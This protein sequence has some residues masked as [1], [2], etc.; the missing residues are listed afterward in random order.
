MPLAFARFPLSIHPSGLLARDGQLYVTVTGPSIAIHHLAPTL[1]IELATV[2]GAGV[3]MRWAA[4]VWM[5]GRSYRY[6]DDMATIPLARF[7][8]S[9]TRL[10]EMLDLCCDSAKALGALAARR[11]SQMRVL[12][13][14]VA[15][16]HLSSFVYFV[17][18]RVDLID[19]ATLL[20]TPQATAVPP[21]PDAGSTPPSLLS[22]APGSLVANAWV[23]PP[24]AALVVY[25]S[26]S[27]VHLGAL[28]LSVGPHLAE[29]ARAGG[30]NWEAVVKMVLTAALSAIV[31]PS[32]LGA[33]AL[34]AWI[35]DQ[36]QADE[37]ARA[38]GSVQPPEQ[39]EDLHA[40]LLD[41]RRRLATSLGSEGSSERITVE[42]VLVAVDNYEKLIPIVGG[43]VYCVAEPAAAL[44][45]VRALSTKLGVKAWELTV[46]G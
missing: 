42:N 16:K 31:R 13:R 45:S 27:A 1:T 4:V 23:E 32:L 19:L 5:L 30:G 40:S 29:A 11:P 43:D 41:A 24:A 37:F 17:I 12:L 25:G 21:P 8:V 14:R 18:G 20:P 15:G 34:P 6:A 38:F 26:V 36:A 28:E 44:T 33:L 46:R 2:G 9:A 10:G 7:I 22:P 39:L 35:D 3:G